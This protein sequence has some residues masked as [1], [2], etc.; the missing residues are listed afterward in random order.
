[1]DVTNFLY[2]HM[3]GFLSSRQDAG[4]VVQAKKDHHAAVKP[5]SLYLYDE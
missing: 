4:H 3:Q 2:S 1:M 5:V